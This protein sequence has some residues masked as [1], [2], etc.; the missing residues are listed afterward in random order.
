MDTSESILSKLST[1]LGVSYPTQSSDHP[2]DPLSPAEIEATVAAI[3]RFFESEVEV[4][5][6]R[7]WF[8]STQLI[9]PD[10]KTLSPFL[11]EWNLKHAKGERMEDD[12]PR[13]S[14]S[15]VGV[16]SSD[17]CIWYGK[18]D[19]IAFAYITE[20]VAN[21]S[22]GSAEV[23]TVRPVPGQHHVAADGMEMLMAEEA[24]LNDPQFREVIAKLRLPAD[25]KVV[26]DGWIYGE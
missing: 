7:L 14:D 16:K 3:R 18:S 15:L 21:V 5:K 25:A 24:L 12:L 13:R 22:A 19:S 23:E 6:Q 1:K 4:A 11:D 2:L 17:G 26:A 20:I 8:K 10:K 9:D